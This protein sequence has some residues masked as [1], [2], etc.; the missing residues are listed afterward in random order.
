MTSVEQKMFDLL[1][2]T[3][4]TQ[5]QQLDAQAKQLDAQAKQL[6]MQ[7]KLL[8]EQN[9]YIKELLQ[10]IDELTGGPKDSHNSSKPPSS[11]GYSKPAPKS[12]KKPSGKKQG[13]QKG[14]KGHSL[15]IE[16]EPT[17]IVKHY[18][19][20]CSGCPQFG[21]C[22]ERICE[23]RYDIDIRIERTVVLHEQIECICPLRGS[24]KVHGEFPSHITGTKQYG[25]NV[26]ALIAMLFNVG[27]VSYDR[28][29]Q[30][31]ESIAN[32]AMSTGTVHNILEDLSNKLTTPVAAIRSIISKLPIVHFDETGLRVE[33][34]LHWVHSC[35][36]DR[37][38]YLSV[39]KKRGTAAMDAIDILPNYTGIA[40]H[41]CW[42]PYFRYDSAVHALCNTHLARELVYANE[43]LKQDWAK[44]LMELL[45]EILDRRN[46][47]KEHG[48]AAFS[49]DELRK[50]S[51]RYDQ[52]VQSGIDLN[53][54]PEKPAGKRGRTKKG[55]VR[56]LLDRLTDHKQ[57]F[58]LFAYNWDVPFTNNEAE[59]SIRG[60]KVKQ[61]VSGCFR[62]KVCAEEYA[63]T[64]SFLAT[65]RKNGVAYF[66]AIIAALS[67]QRMRLG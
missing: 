53:P 48:V 56:A 49:E 15:K 57:E 10:K 20:A 34:G 5:K 16:Q 52:I 14:H 35:C 18:P 4:E 41:D 61:K 55:K 42:A 40:V 39:Q 60:I 6:E 43:N 47:Q 27:M 31:M 45:F 37:Y 2:Q 51:E 46:E 22:A 59:R 30:L 62:S 26:K 29:G 1:Q 11:D 23:K 12:L 63:T 33:G 19:S 67:V 8:E 28:I 17:E 25:L 24:T 50:F 3:L 21:Q 65:A 58:L 54:I 44:D 13:G 38:T 36:N 7:A 66:E 9:A 32:I 64:M